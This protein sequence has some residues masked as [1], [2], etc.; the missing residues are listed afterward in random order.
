MAT[1]TNPDPTAV[2]VFTEAPL[3]LYDELFDIKAD[4][5]E[6]SR[7]FAKLL[8]TGGKLRE[9]VDRQYARYYTSH[10]ASIYNEFLDRLKRAASDDNVSDEERHKTNNLA[11]FFI[12]ALL[13]VDSALRIKA[14]E[15]TAS[16]RADVTKMKNFYR[17]MSITL[18]SA[19]ESL[20]D[21]T[22]AFRIVCT[23]LERL[24]EAWALSTAE[25]CEHLCDA[26]S[27][28]RDRPEQSSDMA[29]RIARFLYPAQRA[30]AQAQNDANNNNNK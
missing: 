22:N 15:G 14:A 8:L 29:Q 27:A 1:T 18:R 21:E 16:P 6:M 10:T 26:Y 30:Q 25:T 7:R 9:Y 20:F 24:Y 28:R 19:L 2:P 3:C 4:D 5:T 12:F 11:L 23:C 13:T 17:A